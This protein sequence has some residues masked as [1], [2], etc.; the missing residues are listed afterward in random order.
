MP[1]VCEYLFEQ[2][3]VEP[4]WELYK[5]FLPYSGM[6][7]MDEVEDIDEAWKEV[8]QFVNEDPKNLRLEV[9][10]IA[11]IYSIADHSK[12]LLYALQDGALPSNVKGGY[13][14]RL[15]LRR[16]MDFITKY[17]WNIDQQAIRRIHD[18]EFLANKANQSEKKLKN[19]FD[20]PDLNE[21][22]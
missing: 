9:E 19:N 21:E 1:Q 10:P 14:L 17:N 4:N 18:L 20:N 6:L 16:A 7:N 13:N 5:K 2:S 22:K 12:T 8:A 11:G 15:V 3:K